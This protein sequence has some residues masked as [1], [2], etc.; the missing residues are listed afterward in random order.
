MPLYRISIRSPDMQEAYRVAKMIRETCPGPQ[1]EVE[2]GCDSGQMRVEVS[3][4]G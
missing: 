4:V 1:W 3:Y 2:G